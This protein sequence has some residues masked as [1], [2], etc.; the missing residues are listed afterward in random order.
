MC[1]LLIGMET[2][3]SA[4]RVK[5]SKQFTVNQAGKLERGT[6]RSEPYE[7]HITKFLRGF[8]QSLSAAGE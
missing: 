1:G 4:V 8:V 5:S 2:R 7:P 3:T 6:P